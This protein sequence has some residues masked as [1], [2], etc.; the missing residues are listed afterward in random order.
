MAGPVLPGKRALLEGLAKTLSGSRKNELDASQRRI[1]IRKESWFLQSTPQGDLV[2]FYAEGD[3]VPKAIATWAASKDP[4]DVWLKAQ[5]KEISGI[6]W[7]R[8]F[9]GPFPSQHLRYGY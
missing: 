1:G 7:N 9:P 4:F 8:P 3:D 5:L 2:I 6:D